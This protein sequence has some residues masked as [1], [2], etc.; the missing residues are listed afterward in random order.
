M[1]DAHS[2]PKPLYLKKDLAK[3][4]VVGK[5]LDLARTVEEDIVL[6]KLLQ[7]FS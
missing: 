2:V 6:P 5:E 1:V 4:I 3:R 7:A